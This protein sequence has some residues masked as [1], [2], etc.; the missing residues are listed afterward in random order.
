MHYE[1]AVDAL[2]SCASHICNVASLKQSKDSKDAAQ[3]YSLLPL[4][5]ERRKAA[6]DAISNVSKTIAMIPSITPVV[7]SNL[8]EMSDIREAQNFGV[9]KTMRERSLNNAASL[10]AEKRARLCLISLRDTIL[11]RT[12]GETRKLCVETAVGLASGRT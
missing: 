9:A 6:K 11:H 4:E 7:V 5:Y 1:P 2:T 3:K 10:A 8:A 12:D